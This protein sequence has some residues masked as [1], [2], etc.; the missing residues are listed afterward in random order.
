MKNN[1][2]QKGFTL[3]EIL[4]ASAIFA[5]MLVM[6]TGTVAQT[7]AYQNRLKGMRETSEETRRIADMITRDVRSA[8][9]PF[10]FPFTSPDTGGIKNGISIAFA[11]K[12]SGPIFLQRFG[13]P[14]LTYSIENC[15]ILANSN[16][17]I[18]YYTRIIDGQ[19][20][21]FRKTYP[22]S[23]DLNNIVSSDF[24]CSDSDLA[25]FVGNKDNAI[26]DK[27]LNVTLDLAGFAP[28]DRSANQQPFIKFRTT[29]ETVG[30]TGAN[31]YKTE[32]DSTVTSRSYN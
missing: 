19:G 23:A 10:V 28:D 32:I 22:S 16:E 12:G 25:C 7:S 24:M 31:H 11:F 2:K 20:Y 29:A 9:K 26:S 17:Y 6:V 1:F 21:L 14:S 3:L 15:M 5:S 27:N 13:S 30:T 8:N 4:I 18:F